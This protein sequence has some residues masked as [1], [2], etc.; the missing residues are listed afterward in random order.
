MFWI[1]VIQVST[2]EVVSCH[3]ELGCLRGEALL[4]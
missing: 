3:M 4:G 1:P 2:S